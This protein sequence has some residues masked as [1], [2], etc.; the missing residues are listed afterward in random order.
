MAT[1]SG[2]PDPDT[3]S[4]GEKIRRLHTAHA[5]TD[6][7]GTL[8]MMGLLASNPTVYGGRV[9]RLSGDADEPHSNPLD[10]SGVTD[11]QRA[12]LFREFC[13]AIE[14]VAP[15]PL[16][17]PAIDDGDGKIPITY[18]T[19]GLGSTGDDG[20]Q[21]YLHTTDETARALAEREYDGF[22][23]YA[24]RPEHG[25]E[26][27]CFR[28]SDDLNALPLD[29]T[30]ETLTVM[31]GSGGYHQTYLNDGSVGNAQPDC[32]EMKATNWPVIV[33]GSIHDTGGIY[34][35]ASDTDIATIGH[36]D[37]PD[38]LQGSSTASDTNT[39][40]RVDTTDGKCTI[41]DSTALI[42]G[43]IEVNVHQSRPDTHI[44]DYRNQLGVSLG[45]I[46]QQDWKLN[47]RLHN[48]DPETLDYYSDGSPDRSKIDAHICN[49]L[50]YHWFSYQQ[51]VDILQ[52]TRWRPAL[53]RPNY[54][55]P[56]LSGNEPHEYGDYESTRCHD[57]PRRYLP[58]LPDPDTVTVETTVEA[59][60]LDE[61]RSQRD[62]VFD[63]AIDTGRNTLI[64]GTCNIGKTWRAVHTAVENDVLVTH[65]TSRNELRGDVERIADNAD[66]SCKR[67]YSPNDRC[68]CFTGEHGE[69]WEKRVTN[70]QSEKDL[71]ARDMHSE[72]IDLWG[73]PMPCDDGQECP[74]KSQWNNFE[75]D[76]YDVITCHYNHAWVDRLTNGRVCIVD[77]FSASDYLN[78]YSHETVKNAVTTFCSQHDTLP[79]DCYDDVMNEQGNTF[80]QGITD[81][82]FTQH[83]DTQR[84]VDFV[85]TDETDNGHI[86]GGL[87]T[88]ALATATDL[89]NN[90][91]C[92]T[93]DNYRI[94]RNRETGTMHILTPPPF[95]GA[96][97]VIGLDGTP[98]P[99]LW[100]MVLGMDLQHIPILDEA[101][102]QAYLH[103]TM[104]ITVIQCTDNAAYPNSSGDNTDRHRDAALYTAIASEHDR[105]IPIIAPNSA[106]ERYDDATLEHVTDHEHY[107]NLKGSNQFK[108]DD[109][110]IVNYSPH[111]GNDFP[112]LWA[113]VDAQTTDR[114]THDGEPTTG[115]ATEYDTDIGNDA[116][117]LMREAQVEQ[118]ALRYGRTPDT[119]T[120]IYT[121][122]AATDDLPTANETG[123]VC[124]LTVGKQEILRT[125]CEAHMRDDDDTATMTT[126]EIDA[127]VS[128][129]ERTIRRFLTTL[130]NYEYVEKHRPG[131]P[132]PTEWTA[133]ERL[134]TLH[135]NLSNG[136]WIEQ[137]N[138]T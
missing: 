63:F 52:Q 93:I 75:T 35:I 42:N 19:D 64:D 117:Y 44:N 97:V 124:S 101:T 53:K 123:T 50:R 55:G 66:I 122:T 7:V 29:A 46:R 32:G 17:V 88:R 137:A 113:A 76:E 36:D 92:V 130:S 61:A 132:N 25:T 67:I 37:L 12:E 82:W 54:I 33:P 83:K 60:T 22:L 10:V 11:T 80:M 111:Y 34:H 68:P 8:T 87:F 89:G 95:D 136:P 79:F 135:M 28:D 129:S 5:D 98:A 99:M 23:I 26:N 105:D 27:L 120:T 59:P 86:L 18:T 133:T 107:G 57:S 106:I 41:D 39:G 24:G 74:Y 100:D 121:M 49:Q 108:H 69:K 51:I 45:D 114:I 30:P 13:R 78:E 65:F 58:L 9:S 62:D 96:D 3:D 81:E 112:R 91:E 115:M 31:S 119:D 125:L 20:L 126:P 134:I 131:G 73:E 6:Q 84:S 127:M 14:P 116:L 128:P 38:V 40:A 21:Q 71:T 15:D 1:Q 47:E 48:D 4:L 77:E 118:A 85:G 102:K 2:T 109:V 103:A 110:G 104:G 16:F 70:A 72:A 94:V 43:E 138:E 56:T 90:W